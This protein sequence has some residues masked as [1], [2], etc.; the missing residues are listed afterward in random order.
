MSEQTDTRVTGSRVATWLGW[1]LAGLLA[2]VLALAIFGPSSFLSNAITSPTESRDT[3]VI[4]AVTKEEKVVLLNLGIQGLLEESTSS[5]VLGLD[6]PW[7]DR[8]SFVQYS[9]D[10]RLGIDGRGVTIEEVREDEYVISI[11][12]FIFIGHDDE[13]FQLVAEDNGVLSWVTPE[14]D[15][16]EMINNILD[17]GAEKSYLESNAATLQQQAATFY[18][19]IV[20]SIDPDATVDF[21]FAGGE[22]EPD[23]VPE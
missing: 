14:I 17:N 1:I 3:S 16:V 9:F 12:E 18:R 20:T 21:E 23:S 7:S 4:A 22:V 8:T 11:P 15:P 19:G 6:I 2:I 10:A 5:E 13:S